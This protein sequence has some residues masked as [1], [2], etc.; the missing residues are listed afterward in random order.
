M[1]ISQY[2]QLYKDNL[3][4]DVVPFWMNNSPDRENG[5]YFTCLERE[6]S[7]FDADKFIWLQGRQV[8][9]FSMLYN[10]VEK[11][12]DWLD[13]AQHGADFLKKY[14]RAADGSWYFSLTKD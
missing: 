2:T 10:N 1:N 12:Q 4:N 6:G 9:M 14:G 8:W 7:V 13:F 3:L 11:K 5:G